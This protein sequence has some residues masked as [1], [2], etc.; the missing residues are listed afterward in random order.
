MK[1]RKKYGSRLL[2]LIAMTKNTIREIKKAQQ[3]S[4]RWFDGRA[5]VTTEEEEESEKLEESGWEERAS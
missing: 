4:S 5:E 2:M 1:N 3:I